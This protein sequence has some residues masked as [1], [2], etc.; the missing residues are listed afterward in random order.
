MKK[1]FLA[2]LIGLNLFLLPMA[3]L[4]AQTTKTPQTSDDR[5]DRFKSQFKGAFDWVDKSYC[6]ANA[7]LYRIIQIVLGIT[8]GVA[9]LFI[10]IG[11]FLYITS[12]GNAEQ[13]EKGQ[14]TLTNAVIGLVVVILAFVIV[15]VIA[16]T[17]TGGIGKGAVKATTSP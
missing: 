5:C 1:Y 3:S 6:T 2:I 16:N 8:G 10:I 14:S 15:R 12:A 4:S 9:V 13:A 17:V 7:L 11:G